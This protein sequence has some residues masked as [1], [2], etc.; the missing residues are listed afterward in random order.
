[1]Q[2]ILEDSRAFLKERGTWSKRPYSDGNPLDIELS[3]S[4][5][6]SKGHGLSRSLRFQVAE[7]LSKDAAQFSGR[8]AALRHGHVAAAGKILDRL[9]DLSRLPV[10]ET[11]LDEQDRLEDKC[12]KELE[13]VGR[14]AMAV[15]NQ[16]KRFDFFIALYTIPYNFSSG[17][18]RLTWRQEGITKV[19]LLSR[20]NLN[21]L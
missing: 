18:M 16:W 14:F 20:M 8:V 10:P 11:M 1:M 4:T 3:S 2:E 19:F 21:V 6:K 15:V 13:T 9:I 12:S 5:I 7:G 17:L